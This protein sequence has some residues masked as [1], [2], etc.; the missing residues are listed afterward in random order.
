[1]VVR[2]GR[3][4][5]A[6]CLPSLCVRRTICELSR[7]KIPRALSSCVSSCAGDPPLRRGSGSRPSLAEAGPALESNPSLSTRP[8]G[9]V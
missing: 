4:Y 1:M 2:Y 6:V 3:A 8:L 5:A 7:R 9:R